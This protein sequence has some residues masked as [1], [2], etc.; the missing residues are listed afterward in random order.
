MELKFAK[1]PEVKLSYGMLQNGAEWKSWT[2]DVLETLINTLKSCSE[3]DKESYI[4]QTATELF[5]EIAQ[6][7]Y[8]EGQDTAAYD[9]GEI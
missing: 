3:T 1:A 6:C 8:E 4:E 5:E 7:G 2:K 9:Y